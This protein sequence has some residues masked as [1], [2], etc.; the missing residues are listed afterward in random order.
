MTPAYGGF[1]S[2]Q[3]M[4]APF[5][6]SAGRSAVHCRPVAAINNKKCAAV[7]RTW[8]LVIPVERRCFTA[9]ASLWF[10]V[11][12][13][14]SPHISPDFYC[15]H[16]YHGI[17]G[18]GLVRRLRRALTRCQPT[19]CVKRPICRNLRGLATKPGEICGLE[20]GGTFIPPAAAATLK[21]S[22]KGSAPFHGHRRAVSR[23]GAR[24]CFFLLP[25]YADAGV[26]FNCRRDWKG[27]P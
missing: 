22:R 27:M 23:Y 5:R 6:R 26:L 7:C 4:R 21:P 2:R 16:A 15:D 11:I 24:R 19:N 14:I 8:R 20:A 25:L 1:V 10:M 12:V 9:A 17:S 13:H 18:A 3:S